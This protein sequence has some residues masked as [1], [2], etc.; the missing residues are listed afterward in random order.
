[1]M[2]KQVRS[3][4]QN[5]TD[6]A[7]QHNTQQNK[8]IKQTVKASVGVAAGAV[9]FVICTCV[10]IHPGVCRQ[11]TVHLNSIRLNQTAIIVF[12]DNTTRPGQVYNPQTGLRLK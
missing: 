7:A 2:D 4:Q 1:M 11:I 6:N 12:I 10:Y 9:P 3:R 5:L 8:Y